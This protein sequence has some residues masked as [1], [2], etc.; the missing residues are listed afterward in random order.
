MPVNHW[1]CSVDFY[2]KVSGS[3]IFLSGVGFRS[4]QPAQ[5]L[6]GDPPPGYSQKKKLKKIYPDRDTGWGSF[7]G[8]YRPLDT[9]SQNMYFLIPEANPTN[10]NVIPMSFGMPVMLACAGMRALC[11]FIGCHCFLSLPL[12]ADYWLGGCTFLTWW[13]KLIQ[14]ADDNPSKTVTCKIFRE[15]LMTFGNPLIFGDVDR[16]NPTLVPQFKLKRSTAR[17]M[18]QDFFL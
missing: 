12:R 8:S 4:D 5:F 7:Q 14:N 15:L 9:L 18:R 16:H 2:L 1:F 10:L 6:S 13:M 11:V 3:T 17:G